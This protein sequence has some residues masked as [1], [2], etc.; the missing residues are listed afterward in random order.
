MRFHIVCPAL[1]VLLA[2]A[3]SSA[4]AAGNACNGMTVGKLTGLNGFVPF[5]ADNPWNTDVSN[6]PLDPNS[7]NLINYIGADVTLHP[8]FG[9]GTYAGQSIGIPYQVVAGSQPK[10]TSRQVMKLTLADRRRP[11]RS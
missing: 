1:I 3:T 4:L 10:V 11:L 2:C 9:S 5:P 8:D 7:D 6:A